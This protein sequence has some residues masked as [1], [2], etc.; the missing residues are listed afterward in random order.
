[1]VLKKNLLVLILGL[2]VVCAATIGIVSHHNAEVQPPT[3]TKVATDSS[4]T[5]VVYPAEVQP[6]TS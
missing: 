2:L 1:M 4:T 6:P 3:S 5:T